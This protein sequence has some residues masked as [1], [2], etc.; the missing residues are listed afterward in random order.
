LRKSRV[1]EIQQFTSTP[2]AYGA[3]AMSW[4]KLTTMR[5]E[6][7]QQSTAEYIRNGGG[8][9]DKAAMIF[10][11]RYIAGVDNGD[12]VK[13]GNTFFNIK[14]TIVEGRNKGLEL[15]CEAVS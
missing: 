12:R 10:R 11:T 14:E 5:A 7:V 6:I 15:R 8:A 2:D 9:S 1:I 3:P 13:F 4:V